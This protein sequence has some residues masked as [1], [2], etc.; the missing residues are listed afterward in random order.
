MKS[1]TS[2]EWVIVFNI[3][4]NG[5]SGLIT[6]LAGTLSSYIRRQP[7][8]EYWLKQVLS[9]ACMREK[10]WCL[11]IL[12]IGR[13]ILFVCP[14]MNYCTIKENCNAPFLLKFLVIQIVSL[15]CFPD[16][17]SCLAHLNNFG[18][19]TFAILELIYLLINTTFGIY[20]VK[21]RLRTEVL[22]TSSSTQ[23]G[24]ELMTSRSWYHISCHWDSCS[25]HS[26]ISDLATFCSIQRYIYFFSNWTHAYAL[27]HLLG[28]K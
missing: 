6:V 12:S 16:C 27:L 3:C 19:T 15:K 14:I 8:W 25:N 11:H 7:V 28:S 13:H 4:M 2:S 9:C 22:R 18:L 23:P 21:V 1:N 5:M 20:M 26:A 17:P 24:F 10:L